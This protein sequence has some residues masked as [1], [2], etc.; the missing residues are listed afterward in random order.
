MYARTLLCLAEFVAKTDLSYCTPRLAVTPFALL[1][2][3][4]HA[5]A[6]LPPRH[7]SAH[8]DVRTTQRHDISLC[9]SPCLMFQTFCSVAISDLA[10]R[11]GSSHWPT[12]TMDVYQRDGKFDSI[13]RL[14]FERFFCFASRGSALDKTRYQ[15]DFCRQN[16]PTVIQT[17]TFT[18]YIDMFCGNHGR[19]RPL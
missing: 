14:R 3:A 2:T 13:S 8:S 16:S 7:S 9:S 12:T 17:L 10:W 18:Y 1:R 6:R 4:Q 15:L 19:P 5:G 11:G